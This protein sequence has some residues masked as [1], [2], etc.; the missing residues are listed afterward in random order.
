MLVAIVLAL[1]GGYFVYQNYV[2]QATLVEEPPQQRIDVIGVESDLRSMANAERQFL[3][4]RGTY[5]PLEQLESE[6]LL[7]GGTERR[8]Y[9]FTAQIDGTSGFTITAEPVDP[10]KADWP[11]L[12]IDETMEIVPQ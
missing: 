7:A 12:T 9:R 6:G 2:T 3:A 4:S 1:G 8:G 10:D 11:T 5:A